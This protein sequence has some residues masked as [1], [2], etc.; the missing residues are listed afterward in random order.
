MTEP[1]LLETYEIPLYDTKVRVDIVKGAELAMQY[2]IHRPELSGPTSILLESVKDDILKEVRI[3][4]QE[5]FEAKSVEKLG[6]EFRQKANE[7]LLRKLPNLEAGKRNSLVSYLMS[8]MIGLGLLEI[9]LN[10]PDL[11]EI[12]VNTSAE[13][14]WVYHKKHGW[15][16][17]NIN[18][19][20]EQQVQNYASIIARRIG[21]QITTLEPLLDAH[22]VTGDR[23]NAT[24]APIS[25]K[26]NTLTIR[27]FARK[28]WTITDFIANGTLNSEVAAFLWTAIQYELNIIVAGGTSSGKTALLNSL[29][30]F[31]QPNHRIISIEDTRELQLPSFL[32]W[33]PMTSRLPNP[34]GKG[35]VSMLDLMVNSLRMRPDRIVVGE[36]RRGDQAEVLFEAMHT[37]HSVYATLHA[38]T[39]EQVIKRMTN[40]PINIP[41]VMMEAVHMVIVQRRDRRTGARKTSQVAEILPAGDVEEKRGLKVN[42]LYRLK[43]DGSLAPHDP[44]VRIIDL[45]RMHTGMTDREFMA[46]LKEKMAVL[47]YM[48]KRNI[49]DIDE[50]GRMVAEYYS[51]KASLLRKLKK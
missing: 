16:K 42:V 44:C 29:M 12:V 43:P 2:I 35:E 3:K 7:M 15:L 36:I 27:K 45:L 19:K 39:A 31:M 50:I 11:E 48:V 41:E 46:E 33:V 28:P 8:E 23:A 18:V 9:P 4:P 32:H 34:E 13:P 25:T 5:I 14:A 22:L 37:G 30:P 40:P 21:R 51:D 6:A 20:T 10:D 38:D 24:L 26:G 17:T 47:D 1:K 49:N